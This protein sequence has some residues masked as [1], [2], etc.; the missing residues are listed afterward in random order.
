MPKI[1][2]FNTDELVC[3]NTKI[4]HKKLKKYKQIS[5]PKY[6]YIG[7]GSVLKHKN[8]ICLTFGS[9]TDKNTW[10]HNSSVYIIK[11]KNEY[12]FNMK[13]PVKILSNKGQI[14]SHQAVTYDNHSN[15]FFLSGGIRVLLY[16]KMLFLCNNSIVNHSKKCLKNIKTIKFDKYRLVSTKYDQHTCTSNGTYLLTSTDL[17]SWK[18]MFDRP[19]QLKLKKDII[20]SQID[21]GISAVKKT[22]LQKRLK[23]LIRKKKNQKDIN[24]IKTKLSSTDWNTLDLYDTQPSLFYDEKKETYVLYTRD[25]VGVGIRYTEYHESKDLITWNG[26]HLISIQKP[27]PFDFKS[28]NLYYFK[29]KHYPEHGYY[30]AFAKYYSPKNNINGIYLFLSYDGINWN[31]M[32]KVIDDDDIIH[33]HTIVFQNSPM[34]SNGKLYFYTSYIPNIINIYS[35]RVDGY[36]YIT[37]NSDTESSFVTRM[38]S[39]SKLRMNYKS[40]GYIKVELLDDNMKPIL[41]YNMDNFDTLT[42]NETNKI[43]SWN[44]NSVTPNINFYVRVLFVKSNIYSLIY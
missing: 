1:F 33:C 41:K 4:V 34:L 30:T 39:C 36:S 42:G 35:L 20:S 11:S 12:D 5:N 44:N 23:L 28:D 9:W 7:Y 24:L 38:I 14:C 26:P 2:F 18:N 3:N 27:E 6:N 32:S 37:N 22:K 8:D 13:N 10:A 31:R 29:V 16:N 43:L 25:N 40:N 15:T 19:L 17:L 21:I